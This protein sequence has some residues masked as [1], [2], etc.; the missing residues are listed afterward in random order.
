MLSPIMPISIHNIYKIAVVFYALAISWSKIFVVIDKRDK[1]VNVVF[2]LFSF[3][4][5][6]SYFLNG[7]EIITIFSQYLFKYGLVFALYHN[8]KELPLNPERM[9][10]IKKVLLSIV[11]SQIILSIVK[12]ILIG[13]TDEPIV[14]SMSAGGAGLAVVF[15]V[16]VLIYYWSINYGQFD[17]KNW[18][19]SFLIF[20]VAIASAKRQPVIFF[21]IVIV[22]LFS[23]VSSKIKVSTIIKLLPLILILFYSGVRLTPTLTPENK[24]WG[25]FNI[26]FVVDYAFDY[27][28]GTSD[29]DEIFSNSYES[30]GRGGGFAYYFQ[31]KKLGLNSLKDVLYGKGIYNVAIGTHGR[32]TAGNSRY[33]LEH[34]GLM[35]EA[36]AILYSI[37][38]LGAF[39]MILLALSILNAIKN[40]KM[41]IV[42][43]IF[44]FWDF[45]FYYN[46]VV[47]SNQSLLFVMFVIFFFNSFYQSSDDSKST[48][49]SMEM[50][51]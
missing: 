46:Q 6:M 11:Y 23:Y 26:T 21:P 16:V 31:P 15:P 5:W 22:A 33:G 47:F 1:I 42:L 24:I 43:M 20:I 51:R 48:Q 12:I 2:L 39:F 30:T 7:G 4:F 13:G 34:K 10:S 14:G 35:G 38:Y 37:G 3:N 40:K 36:G 28:F 49:E 29:T 8:F 50:L 9:E 25:S 45:L 17:F 41:Y 19:V 18:I 32:F 27:Y 44:Y